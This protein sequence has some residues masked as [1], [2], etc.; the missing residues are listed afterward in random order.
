M[1]GR[2]YVADDLG[3]YHLPLR[4]FYAQQ[5]QAGEAVRLA[6]LAVQRIL[7]HRAKGKPA[8]TIR[9][10]WLL[11]RFLPLTVAF[12][13]ELLISYP[14]MLWGSYL[15]LRRWLVRRDAALLGALAFT[16]SGFNLLHFVHPNAVAVVAHWP[17]LLWAIDRA[18][19]PMRVAQQNGTLRFHR[20]DFE[21][22][23]L[24]DRL[25]I[26]T[27]FA[28]AR[29]R[30][31]DRLSA[32]CL[33]RAVGCRSLCT[34]LRGKESRYIRAGVNSSACSW[35]VWPAFCWEASSSSRRSMP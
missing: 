5:L 30:D 10:T 34:G 31:S 3:A 24:P 14:L 13:L 20:C 32:I 8:P 27:H 21:L 19:L 17:W 1:A 25:G 16:F 33:D 7:S 23:I 12:D 2:V 9:S 18:L 29:L 4:A 11:Y 22:A 35:P 6:P 28:P 26:R 15:L